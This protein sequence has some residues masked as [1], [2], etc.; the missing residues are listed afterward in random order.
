MDKV[1]FV[2]VRVD[3]VGLCGATVNAGMERQLCIQ[4]GC[5]VHKAED[6]KTERELLVDHMYLLAPVS[7]NKL[8]VIP[9]PRLDVEGLDEGTKSYLPGRPAVDRADGILIMNLLGLECTDGRLWD[10]FYLETLWFKFFQG[11]MDDTLTSLGMTSLR[12]KATSSG[13]G[14]FDFSTAMSNQ[15]PEKEDEMLFKVEGS[16]K[17][18]AKTESGFDAE[19]VESREQTR[20]VSDKQEDD[21]TLEYSP[22]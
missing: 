9:Y 12:M 17:K 21:V 13:S 16:K 11:Q 14:A 8:V 6:G 19:T 20:Q 18:S 22:Q 5:T 2:I 4:E 1:S 10:V 15:E 7:N 3:Q